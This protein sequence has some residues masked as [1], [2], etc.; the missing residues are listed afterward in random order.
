[1]HRTLCC[2]QNHVLASLE[3]FHLQN[4]QLDVIKLHLRYILVLETAS[5]GQYTYY[6]F[7]ILSTRGNSSFVHTGYEDSQANACLFVDASKI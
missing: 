6:V 2:W 4:W 5:H 1:M 3:N 7:G